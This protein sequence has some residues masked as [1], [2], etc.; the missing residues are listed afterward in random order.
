MM[1]LYLP[2]CQNGD[3][4]QANIYIEAGLSKQHQITVPVSK[5]SAMCSLLFIH[6]EVTAH[7]FFG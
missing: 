7:V 1:L 5:T 2:L 6:M 3:Q 4:Q